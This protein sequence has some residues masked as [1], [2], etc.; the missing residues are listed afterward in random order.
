VTGMKSIMLAL[1]IPGRS[2]MVAAMADQTTASLASQDTN[3]IQGTWRPVALEAD[4]QPAPPEIA[5]TLKLVFKDN[6]LTFRPGEPG[7]TIYSFTLVPTSQPC[8]FAMTHLDGPKKGE[9]EHAIYWLSGDRLKICLA[10]G[11]Q[12]P[13]EFKTRPGSGLGLYILQ[14][15]R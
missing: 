4:G 12:S 6:T 11:Q 13:K 8:G 3:A 7:Y 2:E 14:R 15:E 9:T 10:S 5:A 1:G